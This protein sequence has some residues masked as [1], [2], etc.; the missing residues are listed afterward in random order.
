MGKFLQ[1]LNIDYGEKG[2]FLP[3]TRGELYKVVVHGDKETIYRETRKL[4][5]EFLEFAIGWRSINYGGKTINPPLHTSGRYATSLAFSIRSNRKGSY[6]VAFKASGEA[7]EAFAIEFGRK[8][9]DLKKFMLKGKKSMVI[10]LKKAGNGAASL[11]ELSGQS[12]RKS[13]SR[14]NRKLSIDIYTGNINSA[15]AEGL[16]LR[17]MSSDQKNKWIMKKWPHKRKEDNM[18]IPFA[19]AKALLEELV[20]RMDEINNAE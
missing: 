1:K 13:F 15:N 5:N 4:F 18:M 6:V 3:T 12:G 2:E 19:P 14:L 11:P 8:K 16:S 7:P 17:T 10:P 20:R 9:I